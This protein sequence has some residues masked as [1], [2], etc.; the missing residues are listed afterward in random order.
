MRVNRL[1]EAVLRL[2][3]RLLYYEFA[4][5]YDLVAWLVSLGRWKRWI[6]TSLPYL[7]G[8][9]VLELGHGPGHL[10]IA[11]AHKGVHAIGI[12]ASPHMT[13]QAARRIRRHL[14]G[15]LIGQLHLARA[16]APD[17]PFESSS[18]DQVIATFPTE[19]IFQPETLVQIARILRS[20]GSLVVLPVAWIT[21][22][23]IFDRLA[24]GLF[25]LTGQAPDWDE[26]LLIP[27]TQAGFLVST[28]TIDLVDS[29]VLVIVG[30][31]P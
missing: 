25:H 30:K 18:F 19:Y 21:G 26:R 13:Q 2:F 4:W 11:L 29:Q 7:D 27:F 12:D 5:T 31:K 24:A 20:G 16:K 10:L 8:P 9:R 14:R 3:F 1:L 15:E 23:G 6:G 17:L 28:Q 22:R